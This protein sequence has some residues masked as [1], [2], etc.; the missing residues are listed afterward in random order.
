MRFSRSTGGDPVSGEDG[1]IYET[2]TLRM[3]PTNGR[4]LERAFLGKRPK[5]GLMLPVDTVKRPFPLEGGVWIYQSGLVSGAVEIP[6]FPQR[7]D[8]WNP[9]GGFWTG[10]T[11]AFRFV[12]CSRENDTVRIVERPA[13]PRPV[14][15]GNKQTAIEK[16]RSQ[17]GEGLQIDP[18]EVP[19][20]MPFWSGFFSDAAGRLWV[21]RYLPP[22]TNP[23][24]PRTW[25][26][27]DPEGVYLGA[28]DL[29]LASSPTPAV[30]RDRLA[31]VV[32][33]ELGIGYVVVFDFRIRES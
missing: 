29:S 19:G 24:A 22:G 8:H 26:V 3:D 21:E 1:A 28:L 14:S 16:L 7:L 27:Y 20:Y 11:D 31:G 30:G 2:T 33:D 5:D 25:E 10:T 23:T 32:Q 13:S 17:Y 4:A 9:Q 15:A 6:F 12:L 18:D